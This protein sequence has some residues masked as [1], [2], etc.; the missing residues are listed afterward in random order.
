MATAKIYWG[1]N[2]AGTTLKISSSS[3][4]PAT[5]LWTQDDAY[6]ESPP[7]QNGSYNISAVTTLTFAGPP[8]PL[9]TYEW[10]KNFTGLISPGT[11]NINMKKV[12]D[13]SYMFSGCSNLT[14]L[15]L[16]TTNFCLSKIETTRDM[17]KNC[18]NLSSLTTTAACWTT[19]AATLEDAQSMFECCY[20][21]SN[22]SFL[23]KIKT[24]SVLR[25]VGGMLGGVGCMSGAEKTTVDLTGWDLSNINGS[26]G[27]IFDGNSYDAVN[28]TTPIEVTVTNM[29]L[30]NQL[31]GS[32]YLIN[33]AFGGACT[34]HYDSSTSQWMGAVGIGS[35]IG[36]DTV[37][38]SNL[39]NMNE[40]FSRCTYYGCD[41]DI[42]SWDVSNVKSVRWFYSEPDSVSSS[43]TKLNLSGCIFSSLE[44]AERMFKFNGEELN[45]TGT[46]F[47]NLKYCNYT[48]MGSDMSKIIFDNIKFSN[49]LQS[50]NYT[51]YRTKN[52]DWK[53]L[54]HFD[55]SNVRQLLYCF[56]ETT[57]IRGDS[58]ILPFEFNNLT[59][60]SSA[61]KDSS[62]RF[63]SI[64]GLAKS[65]ITD[66]SWAFNNCS[67][68]ET[69]Y[70]G[71][72]IID[73][74]NATNGGLVFTGCTS[75]VGGSGTTYSSSGVEDKSY[76]RCDLVKGN[77]GITAD[78][79]GYFSAALTMNHCLA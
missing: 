11:I 67:N 47:S 44:N 25:N 32:N 74:S 60:I 69:I 2:A 26:S 78:Q 79:K 17:F 54:D 15:A 35:F 43:T 18:K 31:D 9:F 63:I 5:N 77:A 76:A 48:F 75:L 58:I 10:F 72:A 39:V 53:I 49:K 55:I 61:F 65:P 13:A 23:P 21:L 30:G 4:S 7:W 8:A 62:V 24:S 71:G 66:I 57:Q 36:L 41:I 51:F 28:G 50:L 6:I 59:S 73:W 46:D 37:N 52:F 27:G 16:N 29:I 40:M 64:T 33:R 19:T 68:L 38:T 14:T 22:F 1:F 20:K 34:Y 56:S 12:T 70:T 45:L 3:S 42:S